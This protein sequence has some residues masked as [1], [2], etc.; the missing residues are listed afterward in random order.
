MSEYTRFKYISKAYGELTDLTTIEFRMKA[1]KIGNSIKVTIPQE[2][3][4]ALGV[5]EGNILGV[6]VDDSRVVV[7][8]LK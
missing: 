7:R 6:S 1:V 8:K 5:K 3:C 4:E 2:I